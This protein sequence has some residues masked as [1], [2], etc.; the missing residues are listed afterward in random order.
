MHF[1]KSKI[2]NEVILKF[3]ARGPS[4][5]GPLNLSLNYPIQSEH[6]TQ[7]FDHLNEQMVEAKGS[8]SKIGFSGIFQ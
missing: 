6:Q 8:S 1:I 4:L 5:G 2:H 7:K 3:G